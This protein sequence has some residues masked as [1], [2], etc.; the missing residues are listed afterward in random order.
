VGGWLEPCHPSPVQSTFRISQWLPLSRPGEPDQRDAGLRTDPVTFSDLLADP[1][2]LDQAV[3]GGRLPSPDPAA[4]GQLLRSTPA[5][6][7][8]RCH[9]GVPLDGP[10]IKV[11]RLTRSHFPLRLSA[12]LT[13]IGRTWQVDEEVEL[14][15]R[16]T[17]G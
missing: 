16:E 3:A 4:L 9:L 8:P 6:W 15:P 1:S 17:L 14:T 7:T 2:G 12:S 13:G 11:C 5:G 10:R